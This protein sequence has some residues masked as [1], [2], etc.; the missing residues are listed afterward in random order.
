MCEDIMV[1]EELEELEDLTE[2]NPDDIP[3]GALDL[4]DLSLPDDYSDEIYSQQLLD[5]IT[6]YH[7]FTIQYRALRKQG[8]QS[9]ADQASKLASTCRTQAA[10]IQFEHPN[11]ITIYK[12][13]A[14]MRVLQTHADRA[15]LVG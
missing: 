10:V 5:S 14:H 8:E 4:V 9:K 6:Q 13:L 3:E 1:I 2:I 7:Q 12:H 15:K 11:T